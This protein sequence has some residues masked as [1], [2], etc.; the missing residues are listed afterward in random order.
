MRTIWPWW[1]GDG[2]MSAG[3]FPVEGVRLH[4]QGDTISR[5]RAGYVCEEGSG[6]SEV[7]EEVVDDVGGSF[8]E[9]DGR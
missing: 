9:E 1:Y 6:F 5:R 7:C 3:S 2:G 8:V 4:A